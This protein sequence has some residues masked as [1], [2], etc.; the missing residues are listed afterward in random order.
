V[1]DRRAFVAIVAAG[2]L[3]WPVVAHTQQSAKKLPTLRILAL[4]GGAQIGS[5]AQAAFFQ[6]LRDL[7]WIEGRTEESLA[8][9]SGQVW[10]R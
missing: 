9:P 5:S 1:I 3:I 4:A 10:C 6:G 8:P 7:G 2:L